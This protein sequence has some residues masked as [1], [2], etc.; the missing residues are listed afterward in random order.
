MVA[1]MFYVEV[2]WPVCDMLWRW[3]DLGAAADDRHDEL[4]RVAIFAKTK[5]IL[6]LDQC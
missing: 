5:V 3:S 1:Y 2:S 4:G 6:L